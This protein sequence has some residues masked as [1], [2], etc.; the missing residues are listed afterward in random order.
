LSDEF[1]QV[2]VVD[3]A[4]QPL[5][6]GDKWRIHQSGLLHR[7]FSIFVFNSAGECLIQ[8]RAAG[9]YH[10]AGKWANSCC[11]HPRPGEATEV[12]ARRRLEEEVGLSTDLTFGFKSRYVAYLDNDMI[13]NEIP[14]L[15]FGSTDA[16]PRL[17]PGEVQAVRWVTLEA[18][19]EDLSAAPDDF[20][21]WLVH[22]VTAHPGELAAWRDQFSKMPL[23]SQ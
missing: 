20:A 15:Y 2:I 10:S 17:N 23:R 3:E 1:E 18:L 6:D 19:A 4:D 13:E 9:K 21:A 16:A 14:Y 12:A 8:Q 11:G 7:A 22:Y 5:S